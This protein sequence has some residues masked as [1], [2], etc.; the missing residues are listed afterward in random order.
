MRKN[1]PV[2]LFY[3]FLLISWQ[4]LF[5]FKILPSYLFPSPAIV[6]ERMGELWNQDFLIPSLKA[7]FQS[8]IV[9]FIISVTIGIFFGLAMGMNVNI[10]KSLKSLFLGLQTLP[11]AA[12]VP[13]SL[14]IFGL[15]G[16]GI[17]F[18]VV[19]S[20]MAAVAI[21]TADGI[22]NI[23]P[24]YLRAARTLGTP[25]YAMPWRVILPAALPSI[26]TGI[27]LGWTLGWHGVV[28]AELIQSS[29]GLGFLLHMGRDTSDM[30]QVLGI[31]I[32]TIIFGLL[33]D[34]FI[35][36]SIEH[37]IRSRWGLVSH[38]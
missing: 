28:S 38:A 31:M 25:N 23:P 30:P 32:L 14:I 27:K 18:V 7:T 21:S 16:S 1:S 4:A 10:N 6:A 36:G 11:T 15:D 24:L 37:R 29:V 33:L 9:G 22:A 5:E 17:Y 26:V 13:L 12:W 3:L 20:S 35:F 8:M 2:I 19:M 34:R